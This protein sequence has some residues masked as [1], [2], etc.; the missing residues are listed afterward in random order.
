MKVARDLLELVFS[1]QMK[2]LTLL[3]NYWARHGFFP[4]CPDWPVS[5]YRLCYVE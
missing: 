5:E 4:S 1:Q 3:I 2:R